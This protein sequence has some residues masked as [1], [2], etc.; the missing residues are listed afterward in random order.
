MRVRALEPVRAAAI[1][2]ATTPTAEFGRSLGKVRA[3]AAGF[4]GAPVI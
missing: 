4:T 1:E 2:R 3:A